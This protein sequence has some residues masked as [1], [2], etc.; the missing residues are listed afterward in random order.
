MD[1]KKTTQLAG[2]LSRRNRRKSSQMRGGRSAAFH[3][4]LKNTPQNN[5]VGGE[6]LTLTSATP[7]FVMTWPSGAIVE[8]MP[9]SRAWLECYNRNG[10]C[11]CVSAMRCA[12]ISRTR[13]GSFSALLELHGATAQLFAN[14]NWF[15]GVCVRSRH[16]GPR[17]VWKVGSGARLLPP[18]WLDP[19]DP[20]DPR[21]NS[22]WCKF[23]VLLQQKLLG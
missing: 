15:E 14:W 23:V 11:T 2:R 20:A 21:M 16:P 9:R 4:I 17:R 19:L 7:N 8:C 1:L 13:N 3:G 18:L 6:P 22:K 5:R 12:K 10:K